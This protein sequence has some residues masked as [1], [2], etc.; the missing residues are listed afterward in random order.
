MLPPIAVAIPVPAVIVLKP[1]A[2]TVP[3]A[4][5]ITFALITRG[6][7]TSTAVWRARPITLMPCV[8][9]IHRVP[10]SVYSHKIRTRRRRPYAD[11]ARRRWRTNI[12]PE[13]YLSAE[14]R[15]T[16]Q[17]QDG[18]QFFHTINPFL[19]GL[20]MSGAKRKLSPSASNPGNSAPARNAVQPRP[21]DDAAG[22]PN[23][24]CANDSVAHLDTNIR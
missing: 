24:R 17:Q 11:H 18:K 23:N 3:V 14:H 7:P 4:V 10:V 9:T 16:R 21:C 6:N 1:A 5:V 20:G 12:D 2:V 13:R 8:A 19:N 22:A 15:S